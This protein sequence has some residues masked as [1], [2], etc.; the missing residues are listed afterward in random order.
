MNNSIHLQIVNTPNLNNMR[1]LFISYLNLYL[2]FILR[3]D[4]LTE[5]AF[6]DK[7]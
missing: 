5:N 1:R 4:S 2:L 6:T 3:D 7:I